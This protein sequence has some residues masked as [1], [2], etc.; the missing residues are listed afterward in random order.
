MSEIQA[1][2]E[3]DGSSLASFSKGTHL[4]LGAPSLSP[5][6]LPGASPSDTMAW[7]RGVRAS[8]Q[9]SWGQDIQPGRRPRV[10][11]APPVVQHHISSSPKVKPLQ[12]QEFVGLRL[13]S[14]AVPVV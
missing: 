9:E 3:T 7:S 1:E 5:H 13:F 11:S 6:H 14:V 8:M 10:P 2:A 4:L 12:T